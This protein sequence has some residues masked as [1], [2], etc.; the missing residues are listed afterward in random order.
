MSP[1]LGFHP[2]LRHPV[3]PKPHIFLPSL[4]W[5]D[6]ERVLPLFFRFPFSKTL[7]P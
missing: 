3:P 6:N 1:L 2:A 4:P 7:F 5:H